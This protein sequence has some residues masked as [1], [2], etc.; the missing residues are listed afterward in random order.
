M[1]LVSWG[2]AKVS[3]KKDKSLVTPADKE[4]ENYLNQHLNQE[5]QEV[6]LLGEET[7]SKRSEAYIHKALKH[8]AWIVDPI[9][10]TSPY[11]F[12]LPHWGIS[13][14]YA[15]G[16]DF[17]LNLYQ[18]SQD[19]NLLLTHAKVE[20]RALEFKFEEHNSEL[21]EG[22]F[23][24]PLR[25]LNYES[26]L[27]SFTLIFE[28][29]IKVR[30]LLDQDKYFVIYSENLPSDAASI[31]VA[32]SLAPKAYWQKKDSPKLVQLKYKNQVL[33][34]FLN[35]ET[36]YE[37][38]MLH[39]LYLSKQPI[40]LSPFSQARHINSLSEAPLP[41]KAVNK[42]INQDKIKTFSDNQLAVEQANFCEKAYNGLVNRYDK[43]SGAWLKD[44]KYAFSEKALISTLAAS[45][46][47]DCLVYFNPYCTQREQA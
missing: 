9:D 1:A 31:K 41:D 28:Q 14:G 4:I 13:I 45:L 46:A 18:R 3:F 12:G 15:K 43:S 35:N 30:F 29:N 17:V 34:L 20:G 22:L 7:L 32:F 36:T 11:A 24:K 40:K 38:L 5:K 33:D 44:K 6:Y 39:H 21:K 47:K 37:D 2:Q 8:T 26:N 23:V 16:G 19:S 10:G 25:L 27:N 42:L